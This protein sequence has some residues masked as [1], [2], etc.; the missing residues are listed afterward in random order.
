MFAP[1]PVWNVQTE[2][3]LCNLPGHQQIEMTMM[4]DSTFV[5]KDWFGEKGANLEFKVDSKD[6]SIVVT[7][8]YAEKNNRFF[9][10]RINEKALQGEASYALLHLDNEYSKYA[11]GADGGYMYVFAFLYDGMHRPIDRGYYE[12]VWG[13]GEPQTV[14]AEKYIKMQI[15]AEADSLRIDSTYETISERVL[16]G[17]K[18]EK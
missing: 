9:F 7:N 1:A 6:S 17:K 11:G 8:A 2:A 5:V 18:E 10:V 13:S 4:D 14:E 15:D 12:L 3:T 16:K